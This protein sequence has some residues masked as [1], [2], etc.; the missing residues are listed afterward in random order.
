MFSYLDTFTS[1]YLL[2]LCAALGLVMGSALNCLAYRIVHKEK[3]TGGRSHCPDCGH[4][5]KA[6]D[7][8]P[9]FSYLALKGRC[10][11]CGKKI[12]PR[13][14]SAEA[15]LAVVFVSLLLR[16]GLSLETPFLMILCACLFCLSLVDLD[17]QIIPDRFLV[18]GALS[19]LV[20]LLLANGLALGPIWYSLWHGLAL[21]GSVL[22]LS[23]IMDKV[24]GKESMGGG[25]I[26]LLFV[27][28]LYFDL[29]CCLFLL[30]A[31]CVCGILLALLL[32][33]KK[34]IA[35]PF[36]PALSIAAWLTLLFGGPITQW[37]MGLF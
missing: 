29:P 24:L 32:S 10:R 28:G 34:G 33:A 25:D 3:W 35:F 13:Y 27:L 20:Y 17:I 1:I 36:G 23:L 31:A 4:D 30:I 9:L 19:R 21:G 15:A 12:S 7:L 18:I 26:K 11:Y 22:I 16:Y 5:L 37:Y 6:S 2:V 8:I 14:P